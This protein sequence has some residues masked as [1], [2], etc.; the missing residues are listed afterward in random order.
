MNFIFVIR[1]TGYVPKIGKLFMKP[2]IAAALCGLGALLTYRGIDIVTAEILSGRTQALVC[3]VPSVGVAV[4][5]YVVALAVM[6]GL[7]REDIMMLPK[8]S[9]ICRLLTKFKAM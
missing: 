4:V 3:L 8:G 7:V 5:I 6:K 1:F 9:K 2:F